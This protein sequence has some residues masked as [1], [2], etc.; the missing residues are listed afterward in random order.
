M[1][2]RAG[3]R[4]FS[5]FHN[6]LGSRCALC[7][8]VCRGYR[9]PLGKERPNFVDFLFRRIWCCSWVL[10]IECD[11][12]RYNTL[13]QRMRCERD[14]GR[15]RLLSFCDTAEQVNQGQGPD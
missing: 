13:G 3:T 1:K 8:C 14:L 4:E 5:G 15:C 11:K 12:A 6:E 7:G 10:G 9:R 2:S